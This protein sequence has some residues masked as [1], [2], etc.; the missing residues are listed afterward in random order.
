MATTSLS[1]ILATLQNGV[2]AINDLKSALDTIFPQTTATST[3]ASTAAGVTTFTSSQARLFLSV[4]TSTGGVY[5]IA[6]Y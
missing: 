3:I 1:D 2:T 5:K 6:A 4:T